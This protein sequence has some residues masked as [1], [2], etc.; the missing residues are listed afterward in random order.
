MFPAPEVTRVCKKNMRVSDFYIDAIIYK[1][2]EMLK[3]LITLDFLKYYL[4]RFIKKY[5]GDKFDDEICITYPEVN[6]LDID[7]VS[8]T[9]NFMDEYLYKYQIYFVSE[10][11]IYRYYLL[12]E[13]LTPREKA[14]LNEY[15]H[16]M[17][18]QINGY[19]LS[20]VIEETV[21]AL[22]RKCLNDNNEFTRDQ[23]SK[24]CYSRKT[25]NELTNRHCSKD[26]ILDNLQYI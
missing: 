1:A 25:N 15:V 14:L 7:F 22:W 2:G 16:I 3:Q 10:Y 19:G 12:K 18:E 9:I 23:I 24:Y 17:D 26:L 4:S 11:E 5:A 13:T 8:G 6:I 21:A 20:D